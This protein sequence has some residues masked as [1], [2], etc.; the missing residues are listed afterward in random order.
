LWGVL[1]AAHGGGGVGVLGEQV[2]EVSGRES[3]QMKL[4]F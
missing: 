1:V 4:I 2:V 3:D